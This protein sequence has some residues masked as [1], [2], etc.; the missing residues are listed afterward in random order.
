MIIINI[1]IYTL[2][3]TDSALYLTPYPCVYTKLHNHIL[4]ISPFI[5]HRLLP[6]KPRIQ[7]RSKPR[8]S[9]D[10]LEQLQTRQVIVKPRIP[11]QIPTPLPD[12]LVLAGQ[13]TLRP[14]NKQRPQEIRVRL[15]R[16][17]MLHGHLHVVLDAYMAR[18]QFWIRQSLAVQNRC[19]SKSFR[20]V[21]DFFVLLWDH[22]ACRR[23]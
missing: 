22:H 9:P 17:D 11:R 13:N 14:C 7:A 18:R 20:N 3:C 15:H 16:R 12:H 2:Y 19:V 6:P 21:S 4:P 10:L 5:S 8:L 1:Y 23:R